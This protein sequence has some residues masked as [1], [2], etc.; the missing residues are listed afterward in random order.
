MSG[1]LIQPSVAAAPY[2]VREIGCKSASRGRGPSVIHWVFRLRLV[3]R[4]P[5]FRSCFLLPTSR[6]SFLFFR[7]STFG[8][9]SGGGA[10]PVGVLSRGQRPDPP[11]CRPTPDGYS[12][13]AHCSPSPQAWVRYPDRA[14]PKPVHA[15]VKRLRHKLGEDAASDAGFRVVRPNTVVQRLCAGRAMSIWSFSARG[16][17]AVVER[18]NGTWGRGSRTFCRFW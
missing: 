7:F 16:L 15:I 9:C 1:L 4:W 6:G 14:S 17:R 3:D 18:M 10:N 13:T 12:R 5:L 11:R 2:G 8:G